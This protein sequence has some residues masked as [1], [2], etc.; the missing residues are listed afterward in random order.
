[1]QWRAIGVS[2]V[3]LG[4]LVVIWQIVAKSTQTTALFPLVA[5]AIEFVVLLGLLVGTRH[6]HS[7]LQQL[8]GASLS[9][10]LS[11]IFIM[12]GAVGVGAGGADVVAGVVGTLVTG[13]FIGA[14]A[15]VFLRR[16]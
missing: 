9:A 7:Y 16:R 2:G 11:T 8:G 3:A 5:T 6:S 15:S 14:V 4:L 10:L 1:M 13:V 12:I